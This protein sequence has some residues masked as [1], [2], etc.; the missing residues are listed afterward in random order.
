M[1]ANETSEYA[2]IARKWVQG[3]RITIAPRSTATNKTRAAWL[4]AGL[5]SNGKPRKRK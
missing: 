4:A 3:G 5:T 1:T 2:S